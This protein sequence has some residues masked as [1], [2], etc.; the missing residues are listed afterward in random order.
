MQ[1]WNS[2]SGGIP[3]IAYTRSITCGCSVVSTDPIP[4][5]RAASRRFCTG[6]NTEC[7]NCCTAH[8]QRED[9]RRSIHDLV[10]KPR[11]HLVDGAGRDVLLAR[12]SV[13]VPALRPPG[14]VIQLAELPDSFL[15]LHDKEPGRLGVAAARSLGGGIEEN[16]QVGLRNR[17]K[18]VEPADGALG[19]HCFADRHV[20]LGRRLKADHFHGASPRGAGVVGRMLPACPAKR[21]RRPA[22]DVIAA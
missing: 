6:G 18:W 22:A 9:D 10:G 7:A 5:A 3:N 11:R 16:F 17:P 21:N 1:Q 2:T 12:P 14:F 8:R 20:E 4:S 13:L 15:V 19:E